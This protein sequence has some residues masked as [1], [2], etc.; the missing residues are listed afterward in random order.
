M[1][2]H[3]ARPAARRLDKSLDC[4][5]ARSARRDRVEQ[6]GQ[7]QSLVIGRSC[8]HHTH[9]IPKT[10]TRFVHKRP[11]REKARSFSRCI[12]TGLNLETATLLRDRP[13]CASSVRPLRRERVSES[14]PLTHLVPRPT[15]FA[16]TKNSQP[17]SFRP[18]AA[19]I[20]SQIPLVDRTNPPPDAALS[21]SE[22][23][24]H[25]RKKF[26]SRRV[27]PF[28]HKQACQASRRRNPTATDQKVVTVTYEPRNFHREPA[29]MCQQ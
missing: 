21:S 8:H 20:H 9:I 26:K 11:G 17:P 3:Q 5:R 28:E 1:Q 15:A 29:Y 16:K 18:P 7:K 12:A 14:W 13:T 23:A 24:L 10:K 25:K 22:L 2:L 6:E 19:T 27:H 4:S